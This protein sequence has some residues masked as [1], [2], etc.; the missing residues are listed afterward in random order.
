MR[1]LILDASAAE[2][3]RLIDVLR[4][5]PPLAALHQAAS[6]EQVAR[7]ADTADIDIA[8]VGE[9][10]GRPQEDAVRTLAGLTP[11]ARRIACGA[12]DEPT[13]RRLRLA[14][15]EFVVDRRLSDWKTALLLRP[16]FRDERRA[17]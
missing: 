4:W 12:T 2:R 5:F 14:G 3:D 10:D 1:V 7:I 17:R 16:L 8:L 13:T 15:A 9:V 6:V 11:R